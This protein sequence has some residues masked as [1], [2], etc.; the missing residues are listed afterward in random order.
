MDVH[1]ITPALVLERQLD[2]QNDGV[3]LQ[4]GVWECNGPRLISA[5]YAMPAYTTARFPYRL[6][7]DRLR[8]VVVVHAWTYERLPP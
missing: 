1:V 7:S 4:E 8:S 6:I 2:R 5:I 3:M